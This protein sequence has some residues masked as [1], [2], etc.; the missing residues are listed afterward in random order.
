MKCVRPKLRRGAVDHDQSEDR[1]DDQ[2]GIHAW[3]EAARALFT[4]NGSAQDAYL[5]ERDAS[6]DT[7]SQ[8]AAFV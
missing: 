7:R 3:I 6:E 5:V 8:R 1:K 4:P 2:D